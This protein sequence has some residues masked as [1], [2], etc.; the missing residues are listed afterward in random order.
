MT[1]EVYKIYTDGGARG[2]PGPAAA[3]FIVSIGGKVIFSQTKY[4][5][6]STNNRAEY[7]GVLMAMKWLAE[8]QKNDRKEVGLYIDSELVVNQLRGNYKVKNDGLK[9]LFNRV[10]EIEKKVAPKI[11]YNYVPRGKN[12]LADHL[13]NKTL[14]KY[15]GGK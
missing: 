8:R 11:F 9:L 7:T 4:L 13:V 5:G 15:A 12:K 10:K 3:A 2:N 14:D 1:A 6:K